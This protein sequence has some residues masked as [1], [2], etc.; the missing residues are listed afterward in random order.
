[1]DLTAACSHDAVTPGKL[2]N[3]RVFTSAHMHEALEKDNE[4]KVS[5]AAEG[6]F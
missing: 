3:I 4:Q 5:R 6:A 1:M 2:N